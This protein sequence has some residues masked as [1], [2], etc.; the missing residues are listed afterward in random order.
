MLHGERAGARGLRRPGDRSHPDS[1]RQRRVRHGGR[2]RRGPERSR[3]PRHLQLHRLQHL[4]ALRAG[5]ADPPG[6]RHTRPDRHRQRR[7]DPFTPDEEAAVRRVADALASCC[8]P[9]RWPGAPASPNRWCRSA[10]SRSSCDGLVAA[11]PWSCCTADPAPTT[12]ISSPV[13]R[14]RSGSRAHL[15]RP[16]RRRALARSRATCRSAGRS[17]WPISRRCVRHFGI[18]R[19]TLAGYSWGGLL[20]ILYSLQHRDRVERLALVSPAPAWRAARESFERR[21][22]QRNLDPVFQEERRRLRESGLR[23]RDPAAFQQRI[24]ELSVAPYFF[25][26]EQARNLTPFRV[27]GRTQQE[28]WASLG[29]YDLRPRLGELQGIPALVMH[30]EDDPIPIEAAR[31]AAQLIGAEFHPLPRCGHVPYVEARETFT[32]LLDG[33]LRPVSRRRS[34]LSSCHAP[35]HPSRS[36]FFPH[37][38]RPISRPFGR[39]SNRPVSTRPIAMHFCFCLMSSR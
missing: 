19:L 22:G 7:P 8:R 24:F 23:E 4:D 13:R 26:P 16:A 38:P 6:C 27:T 28:V 25:D 31:T 33:F 29:D 30:G 5:G 35:P 10:T 36:G 34:L 3:R 2:D 11:T 15:L 9:V 39:R 32:S 37:S 1:G 20:A 12:S 14:P 21:F 17:R 18:E